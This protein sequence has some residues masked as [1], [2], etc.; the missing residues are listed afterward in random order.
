MPTAA[1]LMLSTLLGSV[2]IARAV[3]DRTLSGESLSNVRDA[4]KST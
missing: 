2:L 3:D 4:S 1:T